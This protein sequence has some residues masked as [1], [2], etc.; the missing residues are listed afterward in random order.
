MMGIAQESFEIA[1]TDSQSADGEIAAGR[2]PEAESQAVANSIGSLL[3]RV[4]ASSIGEIDRLIDEL[5][6]MR[7]ALQMEAT[8]IERQ[9]IGYAHLSQSAMRTTKFIAEN[10]SNYKIDSDALESVSDD[11]K[12]R[13]AT[14]LRPDG[15][16]ASRGTEKGEA[17][18]IDLHRSKRSSLSKA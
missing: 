1:D 13:V 8:Q 5:T 7:H 18:T 9:I 3:Q 4:A 10:L 17:Q 15:A 6:T 16:V 2:S 11:Q 12:C 14:G